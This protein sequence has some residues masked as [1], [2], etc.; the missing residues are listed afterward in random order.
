MERRPGR[1]VSY[2]TRVRQM[3][4]FL[5]KVVCAGPS[6]EEH[7]SMLCGSGMTES[8]S[9]SKAI[10]GRTDLLAGRRFLLVFMSKCSRRYG[11]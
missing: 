4:I 8:D 1:S 10:V 6:H 5:Q 9:A 11:E 7:P 3:F 2:L